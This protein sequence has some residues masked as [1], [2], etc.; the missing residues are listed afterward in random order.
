[1]N[2]TRVTGTGRPDADAARNAPD[3]QSPRAHQA[4][5]FYG[6]ARARTWRGGRIS[7]T[8]GDVQ[9]VRYRDLEALVAPASYDLPPFDEAHLLAHQRVL[10]AAMHRGTVLPAPY[11]IVFRGRRQLI[12]M[13]QDQYVAIDEGL[14]FLDGYWELRVHI[15]SPSAP[16]TAPELADAAMQ[17]YSELRRHARAAVPFPADGRRLVSAAFLVERT[18]WIEFVE[19]ADDLGAAHP[20]LSFDVTGPWPAYDFVHI[21]P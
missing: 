7:S 11:G 14:S 3:A 8:E 2:E 21:S 6:V 1:M 19:H 4:L 13:M 20:E 16:E 17:I 9:R 5:Y 10:E 18:A 12:H 15:S